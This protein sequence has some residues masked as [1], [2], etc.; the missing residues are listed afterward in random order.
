MRPA[1]SRF[2]KRR[3]IIP[4][5]RKA[6]PLAVISCRMTT[7]KTRQGRRDYAS[8][9]PKFSLQRSAKFREEMGNGLRLWMTPEPRPQTQNKRKKIKL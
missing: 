9:G 2:G 5:E 3:R 6:M 8:I 1:T 7:L 4:A